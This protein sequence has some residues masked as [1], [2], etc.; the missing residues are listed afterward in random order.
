MNF[1]NQN[2]LQYVLFSANN[3]HTVSTFSSFVPF[4]IL[5]D[6]WQVSIFQLFI[7]KVN[8]GT[9]S[10]YKNDGTITDKSTKDRLKIMK[11]QD[12]TNILIWSFSPAAP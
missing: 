10:C 9:L 11:V 6:Q 2:L 7:V 4:H 1:H 3:I 12:G 8:D 5:P